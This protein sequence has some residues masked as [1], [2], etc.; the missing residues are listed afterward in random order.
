MK[1]ISVE[2]FKESVRKDPAWASRITEQTK[3]TGPSFNLGKSEITHLSPLL[4]FATKSGKRGHEGV[5]FYGCKKL[6]VAEGTFNTFVDFSNS[7]IEKIGNLVCHGQQGTQILCDLRGTPFFKKDPIKAVE[8]MTGS[9]DPKVWEEG[10]REANKQ[11]WVEMAWSL[12][13]AI[14]LIKKRMAMGNLRN[15]GRPM[16]I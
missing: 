8:V 9:K 16:E 12:N 10:E 5:T 3:I 1:T 11:G 6:K 13:H 15:Q 2:E 4:H 14:Q 7:G